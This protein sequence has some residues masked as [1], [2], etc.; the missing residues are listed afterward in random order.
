MKTYHYIAST[1]LASAARFGSITKDDEGNIC[2]DTAH[3]L[4]VLNPDEITPIRLYVR[5]NHGIIA[6]HYA[7]FLSLI[8]TLS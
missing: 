6:E 2:I 1:V 8:D 4:L 3:T 5:R 7:A